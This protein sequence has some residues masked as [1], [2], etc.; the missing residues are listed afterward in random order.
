M[1]RIRTI[2][3]EFWTDEKIVELSFPARLLFIGMWNYADDHGGIERS[4]SQL[5]MRIFP[6]DS[7]S[8]P[9]LLTELIT[10]GLLIEYS[11]NGNNYLHIKGFTSH[12][13]I[14]RPSNPR[15][16]AYSS[17][18]THHGKGIGSGS[19]TEEEGREG[20]EGKRSGEGK[21][22][23]KGDGFVAVPLSSDERRKKEIAEVGARMIAKAQTP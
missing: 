18:R 1:P 12:Q 10:H 8:I 3:P 6:A 5:K 14:N 11:V 16:P 20:K 19:G 15:C 2:K 22:S 7:V 21:P 4:N 17:L 23:D 9:E 13:K